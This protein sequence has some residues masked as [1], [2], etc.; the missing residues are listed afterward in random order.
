MEE[1]KTLTDLVNQFADEVESLSDWEQET[2]RAVL[3]IA[4]DRGADR[5]KLRAYGSKQL[6]ELGI[7]ELL[8]RA[9]MREVRHHLTSSLALKMAREIQVEANAIKSAETQIPN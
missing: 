2:D 9:E 3:I 6:I 5:G 8:N 1:K 7:Y 4:S